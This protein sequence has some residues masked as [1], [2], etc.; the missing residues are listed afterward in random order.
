MIIAK[1]E[2]VLKCARAVFEDDSAGLAEAEEIRIF[3]IFIYTS[4]NENGS[5]P[6]THHIGD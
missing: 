5:S 1:E 4:A 6:I 2:K 3:D